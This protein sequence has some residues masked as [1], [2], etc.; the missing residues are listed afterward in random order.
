MYRRDLQQGHHRSQDS[1]QPTRCQLSLVQLVKDLSASCLRS[2]FAMIMVISIHPERLKCYRPRHSSTVWAETANNLNQLAKLECLINHLKKSVSPFIINLP[3]VFVIYSNKS[4]N[5][6][7]NLLSRMEQ[8]AN[9]LETLVEE[10]TAAFL[11]EKKRAETLLYELL[12]R[13]TSISKAKGLLY[14]SHQVIK[15]LKE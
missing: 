2:E 5:I 8:Y 13:Y 12:P 11:E 3:S 10:R 15:C 7:D 14:R 6:L 1:N 9:N 4:G